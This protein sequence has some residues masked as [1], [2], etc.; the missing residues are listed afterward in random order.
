[1][2]LFIAIVLSEE[3]RRALEKVQQEFRRREVKGNYTRPENLH[4]TL[5]FIGEYTDVDRVLD[6]VDGL[7]LDPLELRLTGTGAFEDLWWAGIER[8]EALE[9]C[10][11]RLRHAMADNGIPFDRKRFTPH[12]TLVRR[13]AWCGRGLPEVHVPRLSMWAERMTVMRSDRGKDGM[14]YTPLN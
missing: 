13:A 12:I 11:R 14:I 7:S 1:M 2:R 3:M 5:A 6:V 9:R 8:S 4:L 10:V